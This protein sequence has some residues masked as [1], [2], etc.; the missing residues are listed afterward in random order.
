MAADYFLRQGRDADA[1]AAELDTEERRRRYVAEFYGHRFW[2]APGTFTRE[3]IDFMT[4][5]FVD[6]TKL[7]ASFGYYE[8]AL[9]A[10]PLSE[11]PRFSEPNPI[12][13][14]AVYGPEDHVI[15]ADFPAMCEAVF[16]EVIGPFVV[17]GCGHFL[18]WEKATV[19]N[20]ALAHFF[21]DL[22][23]RA[24]PGGP[25]DQQGVDPPHRPLGR[26]PRP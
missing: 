12:A 3:D 23:R 16:P 20:R 25:S 2:A 26:E 9:G 1:L 15:W 17:P 11:P 18:Q 24:G 8:S 19:L 6:A 5:P 4:E 10:R 7:R 14:L 21:G 13:T 22:L